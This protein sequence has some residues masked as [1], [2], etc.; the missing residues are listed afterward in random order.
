[1]SLAILSPKP[2]VHSYLV[3]AVE[4][5]NNSQTRM[6]KNSCYYVVLYHT[7]LHYTKLYYT[8]LRRLD[9]TIRY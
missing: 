7:I 8:R 1:M 6:R 4:A 9:Y 2:A 5:L 3:E